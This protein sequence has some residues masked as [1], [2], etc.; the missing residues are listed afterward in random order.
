MGRITDVIC[1]D[2]RTLESYY[3]RILHAEDGDEQTR[4]QNNFTWELARHVVGE[5]IVLFPALEKYL[6]DGDATENRRQ[7]QTVSFYGLA[8]GICLV[9]PAG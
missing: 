2:H 5:E 8:F 4:Y 6:R 7:H 9:S 1:A 3:D